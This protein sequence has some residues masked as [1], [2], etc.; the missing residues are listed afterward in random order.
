M[1]DPVSIGA[2]LGVSALNNQNKASSRD[3]REEQ[4]S[5]DDSIREATWARED[6]IRE[7][8]GSLA[9]SKSNQSNTKNNQTYT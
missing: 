9:S 2:A 5:R 8:Q 4:N 3:A 7:E 6:K 1:C